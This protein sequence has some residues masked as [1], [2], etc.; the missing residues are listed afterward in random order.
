MLST[1]T[2]PR[3]DKILED[4]INYKKDWYAWKTL[5]KSSDQKA[6]VNKQAVGGQYQFGAAH[7]AFNQSPP[8]AQ[9]SNVLP[10]SAD[11]LDKFFDAFS[12]S[13]TTEE[14]VLEILVKENA[15]ITVTNAELS[16]SVAAL[17]KANEK[18]S[19]QVVNHHNN[20][21]LGDYTAPLTKNMCPHRKIKWTHTTDNCFEL[22][23]NAHKR[24]KEWKSC[25]WQCG[26]SIVFVN[27]VNESNNLIDVPPPTTP[28]PTR[29]P[30]YLP[31][32]PPLPFGGNH[33][34]Y[35]AAK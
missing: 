33:Q 4:L 32:I 2:P 3:V 26:T 24:P 18:L 22:E 13:F 23:K 17:S 31:P 20:R 30:I 7:S 16:A 25:F 19:C 34:N 8:P 9:K 27:K 35:S 14:G 1:E 11:D 6:K 5:Y 15:A 10:M 12:A 21:N 28:P 29:S